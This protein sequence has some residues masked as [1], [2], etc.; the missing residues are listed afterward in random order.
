MKISMNHYA[1]IGTGLIRCIPASFFA[2]VIMAPE[3]VQAGG[4]EAGEEIQEL[5]TFTIDESKNVGYV[6]SETLSGSRAAIHFLDLGMSLDVINREKIDDTLAYT[7]SDAIRGSSSVHESVNDSNRHTVRGFDAI[8][9]INGLPFFSEAN[10]DLIN[11]ARVEIAKGPSAVLFPAS[12]PSPGGTINLITKR[13][14][15]AKSGFIRGKFGKFNAQRLEWDVNTPLDPDGKFLFR[16]NGSFQPDDE[17]YVEGSHRLRNISIAPSFTWNITNNAELTVRHEWITHEE[18]HYNGNIPFYSDGSVQGGR[19][20]TSTADPIFFGGPRT[21]PQGPESFKSREGHEVL[22]D[23]NYQATDWLGG[24]AGF[25]YQ[26]LTHWRAPLRQQAID[27]NGNVARNLFNFQWI[28]PY[29]RYYSDWVAKF[30]TGPVIHSLFAGL[31]FNESRTKR[32][33]FPLCGFVGGAE[34]FTVNPGFPDVQTENPALAPHGACR[35]YSFDIQNLN[36]GTPQALSVDPHSNEGASFYNLPSNSHDTSS[37]NDPGFG[38]TKWERYYVR[39]TVSLFEGK[40]AGSGAWVRSHIDR[41]GGTTSTDDLWTW[42][43][44]LKPAE[45]VSLYYSDNQNIN[46]A[47]GDEGARDPVN[48]DQVLFDAAGNPVIIG[49]LPPQR[50]ESQEFGLKALLF[51][52]QFSARVSYYKTHLDNRARGLT[53]CGCSTLIGAGVSDGFEVEINGRYQQYLDYALSFSSGDVQNEDGSRALFPGYSERKFSL[54]TK[55][56]YPE[57]TAL[58]GLSLMMGLDHASPKLISTG[59]TLPSWVIFDF[60]LI[61]RLNPSWD[62]QFNVKNVTDEHRQQ[63]GFGNQVSFGDGRNFLFTF[64]HH[65]FRGK[66]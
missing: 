62:I 66:R 41:G 51:E 20:S 14:H 11:V 18:P 44:V 13:P 52:N 21:N 54:W 23:F 40:V 5:P 12:S 16:V 25:H 61:Y 46:P 30:K 15:G 8:V 49:L 2:L 10:L 7:L 53:G 64:T 27:A 42:G 55:Y 4:G 26:N 65:L 34:A 58:Y 35:G 59:E 36:N 48:T 28:W 43:V 60:G 39:D 29:D 3:V 22:V 57:D 32:Y 45:G 1:R 50:N 6:S 24:T 17:R 63:G 31:E 56:T 37:A 47:F 33:G 38:G 9:A 19:T